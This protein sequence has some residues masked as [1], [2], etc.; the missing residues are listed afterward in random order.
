MNKIRLAFISLLLT[1]GMALAVEIQP[2]N[3]QNA[4]ID[5]ENDWQIKVDYS[6][7]RD[8]YRYDSGIYSA[9][10]ASSMM[11]IPRLDVRKSFA[12]SIPVR[13]GLNTSLALS[14]NKASYSFDFGGTP[15]GGEL[16]SGNLGFSSLGLTLEAAFI[17][18]K[19]FALAGYLNQHFH[20]ENFASVALR[21]TSGANGY[22]FQTGLELSKNLAKSLKVYSNLGYRF[23]VLESGE[24]GDSFL[25][26]SFVYWNEVVWDTGHTV[27]PS[28]GIL[29]SKTFGDIQGSTDLRIVPGLVTSFGKNDEI[30]LRLSAPIGL[31]ETS[32][33][34]G[35]QVGL[36]MLR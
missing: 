35:V 6:Y 32:T 26:H 20:F 3:V 34:F 10:F 19:D 25:E 12:T 2:I 11:E 27:N 14:S 1:S 16:E 5:T 33:D 17:N 7:F 23:D 15:Y 9:N 18:D 24:T 30:Q 22:G 36:L 4:Y 31:N 21:P 8:H 13:I 29:G 28:L